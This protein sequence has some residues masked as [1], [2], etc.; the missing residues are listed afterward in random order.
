MKGKTNECSVHIANLNRS[1]FSLRRSHVRPLAPF[2]CAHPKLLISS[3]C[4]GVF[5]SLYPCSSCYVLLDL[6]WTNPQ[7]HLAL[8][9]TDDVDPDLNDKE[10]NCML[11]ISLMREDGKKTLI[12]F[13]IFK[14]RCDQF[15]DT[16]CEY[17]KFGKERG[18][19]KKS[20]KL[21]SG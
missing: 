21:S 4:G 10:R 16:I 1:L 8:T 9:E 6:Y 15:S 7:F 3:Q 19:L 17:V 20:V 12:G 11:I 5:N 13:D 2:W 14:A 18:R